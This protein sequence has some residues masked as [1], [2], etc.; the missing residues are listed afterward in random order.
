MSTKMQSDFKHKPVLYDIN[1]SMAHNRVATRRHNNN[2]R[3][4]NSFNFTNDCKQT[5]SNQQQR[6]SYLKE[7]IGQFKK[8]AEVNNELNAKAR[9]KLLEMM[10]GVENSENRSHEEQPQ[11]IFDSAKGSPRK[12]SG[13]NKKG[14]GSGGDYFNEVASHVFSSKPRRTLRRFVNYRQNYMHHASYWQQLWLFTDNPIYEYG[15]V[16]YI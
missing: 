2:N 13:V 5:S 1:N 12:V 4:L 6:I 14:N 7:K 15:T 11:Q 3:E 16:V 10:S 9:N 8:Q